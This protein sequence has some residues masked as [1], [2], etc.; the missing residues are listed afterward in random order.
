MVKETAGS[1]S[2]P[3][4]LTRRGFL[5]LGGA[6]AAIVGLS[7]C[8]F[9]AAGN[10]PDI[11][12]SSAVL[13]G[14]FPR[15]LAF[16]QSERLVPLKSYEEWAPQFTPYSGIIGKALQEERTEI[17]GPQ[18]VEYFN[19][20]KQDYPEKTVLLHH[21]GRARLPNFE[22]EGWSA[23]WWLYREGGVLRASADPQDTVLHVD[24][25]SNFKLRSD[26][27][28]H[29]GDDLVI[30][31]MGAD[32]RPDFTK[33]EH[34]RLTEIDEGTHRLTVR[35]GQ[36]GSSAREFP[37]GAYLG[38]HVY[39]GP[40]SAVDDRVWLI[41]FSTMCPTDPSGLRAVDVVLEQFASWFAPDGVLASFDGIQLDV[42][43]ITLEDRRGIDADCDG[44]ADLA[45]QD[46]EDTYLQGQIEFTKGLREILGSSRYLITDGAV[47]QE[48][49][50]ASVSG[51]ELE[52]FPKADDYG[53]TLW[54]QALMELELW[55]RGAQLRLSYPLFKFA[56]PHD[57]P[58]S[59][60]RFRLTL[61]GALATNSAVSWYN[62][63]GGSTTELPSNAVIYDEFIG[64]TLARAGWLGAPRG[65]TV[66]VAERGADVLSGDGDSWPS[67]YVSRFTGSGVE[68][69]VQTEAIPVLTVSRRAAVARLAFSI[70]HIKLDG[71][72]VVLA[73]DTLGVARDAY[74]ATIGRKCTMT[75]SGSGGELSQTVTV[76]TTWFHVVLGF[77]G[78]GPGPLRVTIA[79]DGDT[80][81]RVRALRVFESP[82]AITRGFASGAMF[83]NPSGSEH[84]FDVAR[85][86][87]RRR[88]ARI[89]GSIGQ[90]P[91]T[92]DGSTVGPTLTLGPLDA[93]IVRTA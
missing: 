77:H 13:S 64:G 72:D 92:N 34:L 15:V 33:A 26:L 55:R 78:I 21:N 19:R 52:G 29:I 91:D 49:D 67:S 75:V 27:E 20:Y 48:P 70:P 4:E 45:F 54:S 11:A 85:L 32:D 41:N 10:H 40:W 76:P 24:S 53:I 35:R 38:R 84:T 28:G 90:D 66:H 46:K 81:L 22:T 80:P 74:A 39:A 5:V 79:I 88:F 69:A 2:A 9:P 71:P 61:A 17:S 37:K 7:G 93:L 73:L 6:A 56:P 3:G 44:R 60:S 23:G 65:E 8:E 57:Y 42:F 25:T 87:P 86:F 68:F 50:T 14:G 83:A 59:F 16:R 36:Y 18:T 89:T 62:E 12:P 1:E 31:P 30:A 47:G 58:V 82:D 51:I 63:P 43:Q